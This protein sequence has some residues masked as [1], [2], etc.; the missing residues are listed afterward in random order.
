MLV[1]ECVINGVLFKKGDKIEDIGINGRTIKGVVTLG[2]ILIKDDYK[3]A[4]LTTN[5]KGTVMRKSERIYDDSEFRHAVLCDDNVYRSSVEYNG[6][7]YVPDNKNQITTQSY[8][9]YPHLNEIKVGVVTGISVDC[10]IIDGKTHI[11]TNRC[12]NCKP[13]VK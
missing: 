9:I 11:K 8:V 4:Y 12:H 6:I 5:P 13:I 7:T 2:K 3:I 1:E 10:Y